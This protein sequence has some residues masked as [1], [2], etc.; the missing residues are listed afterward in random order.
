METSRGRSLADVATESGYYDQSHLTRDFAALAGMTPGAYAA[1]AE[2][3][4]E[5]RFV[6]DLERP[7][8][9]EWENDD[10]TPDTHR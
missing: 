2:S 9:A 10:H 4:P 6:Q 3:V 7:V 1:E 5:V 8:P